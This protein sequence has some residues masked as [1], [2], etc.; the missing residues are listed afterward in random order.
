[1]GIDVGTFGMCEVVDHPPLDSGCEISKSTK[2]GPVC[3]WPTRKVVA[4]RA[5][6]K[7]PMSVRETFKGTARLKGLEARCNSHRT[8]V[9]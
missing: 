5:F 8:Q 9:Q 6:Q 4:G 2:T 1:M 7:R 3:C